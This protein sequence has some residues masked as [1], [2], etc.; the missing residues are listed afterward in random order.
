MA[1][2]P[3]QR[4][5]QLGRQRADRC[6]QR[7]GDRV[8][9]AVAAGQRDQYQEPGGPLDQRRDRAHVLAEDQVALPVTWH[10]PVCHLG[11]AFGDVQDAR[12]ATSAVRKPHSAR[13]A[14]DPP[15]AQMRGQLSPQRT[16]GLHEQ[17]AVDALV[18]HLHLR[19][20]GVG[21]LEPIRRSAEET[22]V[23]TAC[24]PRWHAT[25]GCRP[26]CTPWDESLATSPSDQPDRLDSGPDSVGRDLT[27]DR[28]RR[29]AQLGCDRTQRHPSGQATRDLLTLQSTQ[30]PRTP[31]P[32]IRSDSTTPQ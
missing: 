14:D 25:P 30:T 20:V 16:A 7:I 6:S 17:R 18:R 2:V 9:L 10:R 26:A 24:P 22:N 19:V 1:L 28:R 4:A 12:P 3:G 32:W 31:A 5:S 8:C 23:G 27:T 11:R 21:E 15:G 29:A 13:S